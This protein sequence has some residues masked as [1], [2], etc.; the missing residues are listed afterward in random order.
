[1][2]KISELEYQTEKYNQLIPI[3]ESVNQKVADSGIKNGVAYII[4]RH[5]TTGIMINEKLECL[6]DDI[7]GQLSKLFPENGDYYHARFLDEYGAM[8][9]NPT[10][11][12]KSM[13][14]G[15]HCIFPVQDGRLLCGAAQEIY[16][17]EF[18]G[19]QERTVSVVV[20]GE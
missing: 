10:G 16:L 20:M 11:H 4:T 9:G 12:L 8:A 14:S 2:V 13:V 3:S 19:P 15:N 6:E 1:M 17:A 18:D 5:T 7:L